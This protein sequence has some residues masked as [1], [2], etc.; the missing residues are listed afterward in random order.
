M[1]TVFFAHDL[2]HDRLVARALH[3]VLHRLVPEPRG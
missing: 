1:A 3:P 2:K